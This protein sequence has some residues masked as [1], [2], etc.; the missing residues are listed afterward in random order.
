MK[1]QARLDGKAIL[2]TGSNTG[3]GLAIA[4]HCLSEGAKIAIHG[5]DLAAVESVAEE[6]GSNA[7]G[8]SVDLES[9]DASDKIVSETVERF[10]RLDG[11]V[12]NAAIITRASFEDTDADIFDQ[13][14]AI[15]VRAPF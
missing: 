5:L 7:F 9:A 8:I 4:E 13:T 3:I 2:V 1:H 11:V 15:N 12:N 10:G 14:T 6:L